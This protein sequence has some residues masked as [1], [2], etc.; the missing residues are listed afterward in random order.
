M[1]TVLII[2]AA[3]HNTPYTEHLNQALFLI[4]LNFPSLDLKSQATTCVHILAFNQY[5]LPQSDSNVHSVC[6]NS[7]R[8]RTSILPRALLILFLIQ[9]LDFNH[10]FALFLIS[11]FF[12]ILHVV[13]CFVI[14]IFCT[15]ILPYSTVL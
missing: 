14:A 12:F 2:S 4:E 15:L 1:Y 10:L 7:K 8:C 13:K 11:I 6:P 3:V 9:F 5:N